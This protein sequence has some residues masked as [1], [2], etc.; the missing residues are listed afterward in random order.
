[1]KR[2]YMMLILMQTWFDIIT[3]D[4]IYRQRIVRDSI[5]DQDSFIKIKIINTQGFKTI[6]R[7]NN[8]KNISLKKSSV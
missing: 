3:E 7:L 2:F 4:N 6:I 1:M 5:D 8:N